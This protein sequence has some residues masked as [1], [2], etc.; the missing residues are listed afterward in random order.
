[1]ET[2]NLPTYIPLSEAA[3]R[4]RLS[5]GA[6]NRAVEHGTIKAV[7]VNGDVAV[8]EEDVREVEKRD[9]KRDKLW[10]QVKHLDGIPI[11]MTKACEEYQ[12]INFASLS[13]WIDQGYIRVL[14]GTTQRGRGHKRMLNKADVLYTALLLN[15]RGKKPGKRLFTFENLP[16]HC[17]LSG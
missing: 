8:A 7:R 12:E 6:L 3:E 14:G 17:L 1:M 15:E 11:S 2:E 13:R 5:V 9:S 16:P 4:Y 10:K